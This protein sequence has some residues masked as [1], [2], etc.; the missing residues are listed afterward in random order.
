[1]IRCLPQIQRQF[2]RLIKCLPEYNNNYVHPVGASC[3]MLLLKDGI[4][5]FTTLT[6]MCLTVLDKFD[7]MDKKEG[8][9]GWSC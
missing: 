5:I 1:M 3:T 7:E 8:Q 6:V 9:V 2:E 4:K